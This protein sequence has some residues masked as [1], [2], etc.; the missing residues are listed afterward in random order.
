MTVTAIYGCWKGH[1]TKKHFEKREDVPA[2]LQCDQCR[3]SCN[4]FSVIEGKNSL[5]S[6]LKVVS[7]GQD[8]G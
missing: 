4:L 6:Q 3:E 1:S 5:R 7:G 2:I 8:G